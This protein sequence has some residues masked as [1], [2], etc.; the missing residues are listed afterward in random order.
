VL[1][2]SDVNLM[3]SWV[4][5]GT[6]LENLA[7]AATS[8]G[9]EPNIKMFPVKEQA[10]FVASISFK[11]SDK[12]TGADLSDEIER[13]R[14]TRMSGTGKTISAEVV[15]DLKQLSSS[16][17]GV[18]LTILTDPGKINSIAGIVGLAERLRMTEPALHKEIFS[19][20]I[21]MG[22][23]GVGMDVAS[24]QMSGAMQ[25]A[26]EVIADPR[27]SDLLHA[28]GKG[29]IFE[30]EVERVL[31]TSSA[32]GLISMP[33]DAV[34][35]FLNAGRAAEKIW[36]YCTKINLGFQPICLP[37]SITKH[38]SRNPTQH[39]SANTIKQLEKID[40]DL[41][42]TFSEL[43]SR[44]AVFMFRIIDT[45][46]AEPAQR[47]RKPFAQIFYKTGHVL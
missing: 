34:E 4:S 39:F 38:L 28:W 7:V 11:K 26:T 29:S 22:D 27:V 13:R 40:S 23:G 37:L 30:K 5:L 47:R 33:S 17:N 46:G 42:N 35:D 8:K 16:I 15:D 32:I 36:L 25:L 31:K 6:A 10:D 12:K 20:E 9:F 43:E 2:I 19:R 18:Q 24:M 41:R 44:V 21:T 14:T 3:N 45:V 1:P